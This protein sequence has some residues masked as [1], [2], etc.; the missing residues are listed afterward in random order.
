LVADK[1]AKTEKKHSYD[2]LS[3][4]E[5]ESDNALFLPGKKAMQIF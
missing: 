5:R 4:R 3:K 1:K 2:F